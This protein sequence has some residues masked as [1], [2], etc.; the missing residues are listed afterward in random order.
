MIG[1]CGFYLSSRKS[2]GTIERK[3]EEESIE[4]KHD[5]AWEWGVKREGMYLM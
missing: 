4:T 1:K 2:R 5:K 3:G